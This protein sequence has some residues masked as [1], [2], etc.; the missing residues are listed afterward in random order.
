MK[1]SIEGIKDK[2]NS[3]VLLQ[4]AE[5]IRNSNPT[6]EEVVEEQ[7]IPLV[8]EDSFM[9]DS[10]V[11]TNVLVVKESEDMYY[12]DSTTQKIQ[13]NAGMSNQE[14]IE[15][16]ELGVCT[17]LIELFIGSDCLAYLKELKLVGLENLEKVM[18][19]S[20]S[21]TMAEGR[22]EVSNCP[23]LKKLIIDTESCLLWKSFELKNCEA[24]G[25]VNIN[26]GCFIHCEL[27]VFEGALK[28]RE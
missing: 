9:N 26:S 18:I 27:M 21:F 10:T 14:E 23:K 17:S 15:P 19:G 6:S 28:R 3:T 16:W 22:L 5:K 2:G 20:R 7:G 4:L 24:I 25:E 11:N 1:D 8:Y 13:M 12:A